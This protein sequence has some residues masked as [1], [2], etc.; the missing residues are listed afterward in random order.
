METKTKDVK[1][2]TRV[3]YSKEQI[4]EAVKR[5]GAE[6][7]RDYAGKKPLFIG[8]L[9]GSFVFMADLIREVDLPCRTDFMSAKSYGEGTVSSGFV[10]IVKDIDEVVEGRD[11]IV[12]EDILDTANTLSNVCEILHSRNPASLKICTFLDKEVDR[13][14]L[15]TPDYFCFRVEN[16]FV[17]GYGLDYAEKFRNLPY[18]G[19]L[20]DA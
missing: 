20:D 16:E 12:V 14:I 5:V 7:T 15:L 2:V 11:V 1:K 9:K 17:V 8:V 18:L 6:I 10:R 3:L 19:V 4:A 13:K